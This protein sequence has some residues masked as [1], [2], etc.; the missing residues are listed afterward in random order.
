VI[1]LTIF[2]TAL[3]SL[4]AN[5]LRSILAM[6]GIIIGVGSVIAMLSIGA[7]VRNSVLT[8]ISSMGTNLL[9]VRPAQSGARGVMGGSSTK[10]TIDD[11]MAILEKVPSIKMLSPMAQGSAQVK[12]MNKNSRTDIVGSAV[13]YALIGDLE[14]DYGRFFRESEVDSMARVAVIGPTTAENLGIT[15]SMV[16]DII[17]VKGINFR[18]IGI[19]KAKGSG[20]FDDTDDRVFV[21]YTT[22]MKILFGLENVNG[23][24]VQ[25]EEGADL[26]AIQ[27][28]ITTLL[29][30]RHKLTDQTENDFRVMNQAELIQTVTDFSKT[31]TFLLGG[32]AA[33]SLLVGG[34]G[35][36]NIMLVTVTER[37]KEIGIRKAIG[38]KNRDILT[39][40][41]IESLIMSGVGGMFGAIAGVAASKIIGSFS[42]FTTL[43]EPSSVLLALSFSFAIG[44]FFGYYPAYR[45][46]LLDPIEC[47]HYE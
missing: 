21:P 34:I 22:A 28:K 32:I 27:D 19:L 30:K 13:T 31:F 35:I 5:K 44:V 47:L 23:I 33:I 10:L 6:L 29:R 36:M 4:Y 7:G 14:V 12:Y 38:A 37:T 42:T 26:T 39:Q 46:A 40:F 2:K 24:N 18:V 17:K 43:V 15:K 20:G 9:S 16:G 8:R 41:L 45:A 25:A 1:F 3:K 11:A